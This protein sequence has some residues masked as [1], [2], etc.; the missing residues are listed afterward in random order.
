MSIKSFQLAG[1]YIKASY[2]YNKQEAISRDDIEG[3]KELEIFLR[4]KKNYIFGVVI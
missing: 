4:R 1:K 3:L 2:I